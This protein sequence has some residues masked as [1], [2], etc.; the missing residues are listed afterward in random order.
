MFRRALTVATRV[1]TPFMTR[2]PLNLLPARALSQSVFRLK[3]E[4][5]D[6]KKELIEVL[7]REYAYEKNSEEASPKMPSHL[8]SFLKDTGFMLETADGSSQAKLIRESG[9]EKIT[10]S[11]NIV[12]EYQEQEQETDGNEE[13]EE[14][15][16]ATVDLTVDI[17]KKDSTLTFHMTAVE[18]GDFLVN[19]VQFAPRNPDDMT[20]TYLGP[21][22]DDLA[23]ELQDSFADYLEDRGLT[24]GLN[25]FIHEYAQWKEQ[26]EYMRWLENVK[27]FLN[28]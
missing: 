12:P 23:E 2:Q 14:D 25:D 15:L 19:E 9:N 18:E 16:E 22:F 3:A 24:E 4:K 8:E 6:A 5:L 7:D 11:F 27:K 10:I 26:S 17:T 20:V 28:Q 13:E 1:S 21:K